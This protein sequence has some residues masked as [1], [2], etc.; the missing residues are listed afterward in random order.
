MPEFS[1]WVEEP[2][3]KTA[4]WTPV[5]SSSHFGLDSNR[6]SWR[7]L[8]LVYRMQHVQMTNTPP[9]RLTVRLWWG[10]ENCLRKSQIFRVDKPMEQKRPICEG[11][12]ILRHDFA[13]LRFAVIVKAALQE[14]DWIYLA[15]LIYLTSI[16]IG[17][18]WIL[19]TK[20]KCCFV[21]DL[22]SQILGLTIK[23]TDFWAALCSAKVLMNIIIEH[24]VKIHQK[25]V[26][27]RRRN[28][29]NYFYIYYLALSKKSILT[30]WWVATA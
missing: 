22:T 29:K 18:V 30:N 23:Q 28:S 17:G 2:W 19:N 13:R 27:S 3:Q 10:S 14:L 5:S 1:N 4:H 11:H 12:V 8:C 20:R 6:S 21:T 16:C 7:D 24:I 15:F 9:P 25:S 26:D